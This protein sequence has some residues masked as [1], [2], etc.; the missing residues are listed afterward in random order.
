MTPNQEKKT[1]NTSNINTLRDTA[2]PQVINPPSRKKNTV[3]TPNSIYKA[4]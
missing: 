4:F 3:P 2:F 1:M